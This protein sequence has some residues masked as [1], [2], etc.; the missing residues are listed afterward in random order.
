MAF[1]HVH[2][3]FVA[4]ERHQDEPSQPR[5]GRIDVT[6]EL[7]AMLTESYASAQFDRRTEVAFAVDATTRTNEMRDLVM[8]YAFG[9]DE[10]ADDSAGEIARRLATAMDRRSTPSL[11]I[12]VA[13]SS[14]AARRI[15]LWTFPRDTALRLDDA[16]RAPTISVLS[17][18][19]SQTSGLRKA[20]LFEGRKLRTHFLTGRAL[21]FQANQTTRDVA[22]F[23]I[24]RFLCC[25]SGIEGDAGTRLVARVLRSAFDH[26]SAPE[27]RQQ[28]YAAAVALRVAPARQV[29]L[30]DIADTYLS[31]E[32][33]TAFLD[34]VPDPSTRGLMFEVRRDVLDQTLQFIV[35]E[36]ETGVV[37]SSPFGEVGESVTVTGD[38]RPVLTCSGRVINEKLRTKHA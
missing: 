6:P 15:T 25:R 16:R 23:W 33:R 14:G 24:R 36:L 13:G 27:A 1:E 32:A 38:E 5:G 28:L 8:A 17:D 19:F 7:E 26:C 37:V 29:T 9:T 2:A 11:L 4:P 35:Y 34:A 3:F 18:V 31:G 10:D 20:A 12:C 21:D 30:D 22:D